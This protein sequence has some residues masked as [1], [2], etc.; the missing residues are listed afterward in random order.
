MKTFVGTSENA[1]YIQICTAL[2]AMLL[3][4][5]L[6]FKSR[7]NWSLSNLVAFLR[8]NLFTYRNLW[9]WIDRPF[10]VLPVKAEPVQYL[11]PFKGIGQHQLKTET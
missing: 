9:E 3:I 4:K 8:W 10:D 7:F 5:Y 6:K 11:L 1:L 2:I